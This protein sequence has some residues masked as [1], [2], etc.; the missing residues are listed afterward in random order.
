MHALKSM[1]MRLLSDHSRSRHLM[2]P[3]AEGFEVVL[4]RSQIS[5][6]SIGWWGREPVGHYGPEG[7]VAAKKQSD[8][9]SAISECVWRSWL[10]SP[11]SEGIAEALRPWRP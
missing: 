1:V 2:M 7:G 9:I 11:Q 6:S 8:K 10:S 3:G 4:R 5:A